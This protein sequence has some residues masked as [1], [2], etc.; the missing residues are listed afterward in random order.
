[1][2]VLFVLPRFPAPPR[3]G[4]Q[5]RAYHHLRHLAARHA[6]TV[7][8]LDPRPPPADAV[9]EVKA[10]GARVVSVPLRLLAAAA[11]LGRVLVGDPRPLQVLLYAQRRAVARVRALA[12]EADVVHAQLVRALAYLP[13]P[14]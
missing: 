8:T 7:A 4:D 10:M 2:R 3:R 14:P 13:P 12:A 9:A 5:V 6:I 1:M 11:S